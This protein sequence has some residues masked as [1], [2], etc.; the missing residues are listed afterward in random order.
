[1]KKLI[2]SFVTLYF[3]LGMT[4]QEVQDT[5]YWKK[6]GDFTVNFSQVSFSN[7]AAGGKNSVS[8]VALFNYGANYLKDRLSWDNSLNLG[9]GLL[10]EGSDELIKSEDKMEFNSKA[11]YRMAPESKW[12][13]SGLLGFRSQF[14]NGYKYPDT[15]NRISALFAPAYLNFALGA[16]YKPSD[17]FSLF[18]SP[19]GSKFTFVADD[20]LAPLFG[21]ETGKNMRAELGGTLRSELKLPLVTNVDMVAAL[22]LFSNYLEKP[23]N[24]DVN[25]DLRINMKINKFLS[26]NLITNMIYDDN[27]KIDGK[28]SLVQWKQLFGVGFSY[29]F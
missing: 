26:A 10:K 7:W 19:L 1:M 17:R 3:V 15:D 11:G 4:A 13:F 23:Q 5:T 2:L 6:N 14:A 9:Y 25:W 16:D 8:G 24:V 29:K 28:N 20:V 12:F 22:G 18:L 27:I 21:L